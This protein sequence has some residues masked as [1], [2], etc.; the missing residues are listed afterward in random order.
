MIVWTWIML[1]SHFIASHVANKHAELKSSAVHD[2]KKHRFRKFLMLANMPK[3]QIHAK[4]LSVDGVHLI[5]A[6]THWG[7]VT[8]ICVSKINIIGSDNGLSPGRRQAIIRTNAG[9]L[10]IG[11]LGT[12]FSQILFGIQT[13]SFKKTHLKMSSAKWRPFVSASMS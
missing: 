7:R 10:V 11:P 6:L 9:I 1:T 8:Q 3:C 5:S 4:I 2:K 12:N 13:L